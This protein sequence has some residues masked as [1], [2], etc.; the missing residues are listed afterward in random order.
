MNSK[1]LQELGLTKSQATT[2]ATLI[3][4]SPC[5]PPALA[6]LVDESRTNTYKI[7]ESL[8]QMGL[9]AKDDSSK[10]IRYSA[11]S[12]TFLRHIAEQKKRQ[13]E[14]TANK[15][16]A[17]LPELMDQYFAY[18]LQPK[19]SYFQG[20]EGIL[21]IYEDQLHT[22]KEVLSVRSLH[23]VIGIDHAT[24]HA[25]R[26]KIADAK[27][28]R[29]SI[30]QDHTQTKHLLPHER[31]DIATSDKLM[32][33]TRTWIHEKDYTA[34]VEWSTYGDKVS[35]VSFDKESVGMII[36]SPQIAD[37]FRQLFALLDEG[38][39]RRPT[40]KALPKNVTHTAI[41]DSVKRRLA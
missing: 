22:A 38:I 37:S 18:S 30:T 33:L 6:A 28:K 7:L 10:K 20:K 4:N 15:L 31:I 12:P 26:N 25:L 13:A 27:I 32:H 19:V 34:P 23:D 2:Y 3:K 17:A 11:N 40:Y 16:E 35:I 8:E 36:E 9:V 14:A 5:S 41:P 39:R 1:F 24:M 29:R 21:K